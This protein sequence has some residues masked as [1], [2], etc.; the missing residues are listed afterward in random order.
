MND[1]LHAATR[2]KQRGIPPF[3][4]TLLDDYG[5]REFDGHGGVVIFFDKTSRRHMERAMGREPVR[6]LNQ[7]LDAYMVVGS[8]DDGAITIGRRHKRIRR[9]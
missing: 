3:V 1:S 9:A 5:H 8:R 4:V 2:A 6:V 7:W